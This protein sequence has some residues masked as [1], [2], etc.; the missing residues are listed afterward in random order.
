MYHRLYPLI[1]LLLLLSAT[2]EHATI[3]LHGTPTSGSMSY[4]AGPFSITLPT[5][6]SDGDVVIVETSQ[7]G[8]VLTPPAG[9]RNIFG[10][11]A[12]YGFNNS[13]STFYHVWHTGD[14]S[15]GASLNFTLSVSANVAWA[16][17][18]YSGVNSSGTID[19][20]GH[21]DN[22]GASAASI[23]ANGITIPGG[24][25]ADMLLMLYG[26]SGQT[27][28]TSPTLGVIEVSN[29]GTSGAGAGVCVADHLQ[30]RSGATGDQSVSVSPLVS[31][32]A[33]QVALLFAAASTLK[34][35]SRSSDQGDQ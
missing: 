1:I 23:T 5:G 13:A 12:I 22:G 8:A 32:G 16:A 27:A 28:C 21:N 2:C 29:V 10:T 26:V 9:Y 25:N 3:T 11:G 24:H 30:T 35:S 18:A 17:L 4:G 6:I 34:V 31:D 7:Q 15:G 20:S 19:A 33:A 14:P